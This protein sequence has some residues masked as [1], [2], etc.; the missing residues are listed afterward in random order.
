MKAAQFNYSQAQSVQGAL[1]LMRPETTQEI[2]TQPTESYVKFCAGSQSMG[3]MLN[4]RLTQ[5]DHLIDLSRIPAFQSFELREQMLCIGSAVTHSRI[6]DG[7]L[8]DATR[9]LLPF[10]ASNIAYRAIRNRGTIGGSA[11]HADP[12]ADWVSILSLLNAQMNLVGQRGERSLSAADFFLGAFTTAIEPDEILA[13][14]EVPCFSPSARWAYLKN[15]RKPGE[16]ANAI[17]GVWL[18]ADQNIARI[19]IGALSRQ[20]L[21]IEGLGNLQNLT[22]Q[23]GLAACLEQA[24][25]DDDYEQEVHSALIRRALK[26]SGVY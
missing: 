17:A 9:G 19:V 18:D 2:A 6:E 20:P 13:S 25:L 11:V 7:E 15:C 23:T 22:T 1:A 26:A 24:G 10:V 5:I 8:P 14:V 12:A 21:V 4:L 3:P 16:F